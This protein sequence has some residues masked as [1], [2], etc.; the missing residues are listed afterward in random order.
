MLS[1]VGFV[2]AMALATMGNYSQTGHF[3]G[4]LA[5]VPIDVTLHLA[6]RGGGGLVYDFADPKHPFADKLLMAAGHCANRNDL[7]IFRDQRSTLK[8]S[9]QM[10]LIDCERSMC[11]RSGYEQS[12]CECE[13]STCGAEYS[14]WAR[15]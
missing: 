12:E 10:G 5:Y 7:P 13:W 1:D 8:H 2:A 14:R 6:G 11:Q 15:L 4:P 3:G 9:I